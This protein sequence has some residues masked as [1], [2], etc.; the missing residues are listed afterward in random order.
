MHD[1]YKDNYEA[2]GL[3]KFANAEEVWDHYKNK[4]TPEERAR[5]RLMLGL[6]DDTREP[7]RRRA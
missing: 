6:D 5:L 1:S 4:G 7:V 2:P 3:R